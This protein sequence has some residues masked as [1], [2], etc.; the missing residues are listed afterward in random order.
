VIGLM[1][2]DE[3]LGILPERTPEPYLNRQE[4]VNHTSMTS[5]R[6][7]KMHAEENGTSF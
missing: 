1:R 2:G 3:E 4:Y 7:E 6:H 5:E